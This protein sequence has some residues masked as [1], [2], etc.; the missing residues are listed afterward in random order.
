MYRVPCISTQ[1]QLTVLHKLSNICCAIS[2]FEKLPAPQCG[3]RVLELASP[4]S[5]P[6]QGCVRNM[7]KFSINNIPTMI[8]T[9]LFILSGVSVPNLSCIWYM[10]CFMICTSSSS[11][12]S[13]IFQAQGFSSPSHV[14]TISS[15]TSSSEGFI[16][17]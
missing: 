9:V 7:A 8:F 16:R 10:P 4:Q 13:Y 15:V 5:A 14:S 12:S 11:S 2:G 3:S 17:P 1:S 6:C